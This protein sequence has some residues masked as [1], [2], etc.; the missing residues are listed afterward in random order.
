MSEVGYSEQPLTIYK[1]EVKIYEEKTKESHG[2]GRYKE[3]AQHS[4]GRST[5]EQVVCMEF[6]AVK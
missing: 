4:E 2:G 5:D 6:K 1:L 3:A